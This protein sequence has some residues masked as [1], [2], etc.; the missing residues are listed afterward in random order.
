MY[1]AIVIG[2]GIVGMSL[3]YHLACAGAR[4]LL[5]DR[6]DAG[7][8][9][10]AGAGILTPEVDERA[11]DAQFDLA[12]A[13]N[14]YYPTLIAQLAEEQAG[15]T[16]YAVCGQLSVVVSED[17]LA[18]FAAARRAELGR[19][20]GEA[21]AAYAPYEISPDEARQLFPALAPVSHALYYP[22]SARVDGRMITEALRRAAIARGLEVRQA[23]VERLIVEHD[24]VAGVEIEGE[25]CSAGAVAIAGGAWSPRLGFQLGVQIPVSPQRGQI[26]HLRLAGTETGDW[27]VVSGFRGHYIVAWPGGRVVAGATREAGAG[28][29]AHTTVA[30]IHS[31]LGEALRVA[32]GL[33][34]AEIAEIRVGLRPA[35]ADGMPILGAVPGVRNAYLATGHGPHGLQLGPYS[36]KLMAELIFGSSGA[37]IAAFGVGRFSGTEVG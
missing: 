1:D 27:P 29:A 15:D 35:S 28:F 3:A 25:K 6:A 37:E 30:G 13:A 36:G 2:G 17:E 10:S 23:G 9:T 32:P 20:R 26:V 4:T 21:S 5:A 33:A 31:V 24:A 11:P 19:Q 14:A 16:G 12:V 34:G 18:P 8:A 7:R 22:R